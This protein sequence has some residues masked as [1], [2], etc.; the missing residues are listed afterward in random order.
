MKRNK[1]AEDAFVILK[2]HLNSVVKLSVMH[3]TDLVK[4][5]C[6]QNRIHP[7]TAYRAVRA[8][9]ELYRH[10]VTVEY[11]RIYIYYPAEDKS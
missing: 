11:D 8:M 9:R 3:R 5:L 6:E 1:N 2:Q 4:R 7:S 10:C